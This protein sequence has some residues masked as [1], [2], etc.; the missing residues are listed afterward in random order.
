M[1]FVT[2]ISILSQ[3]TSTLL[4]SDIGSGPITGFPRSATSPVGFAFDDW[5]INNMSTLLLQTRNYWTSPPASFPS[6]AEWS[7]K[8]SA[9]EDYIKDTGPSLRAFLPF[10]S[11]DARLSTQAYEGIADVFD[12]S[13]VCA[14]PEI[15]LQNEER[16]NMSFGTLKHRNLSGQLG[17]RLR[18]LENRTSHFS[19]STFDLS[20]GS[21]LFIQLD[22]LAGGIVSDLDPTNN[23][24]VFNFHNE[25]FGGWSATRSRTASGH[26]HNSW[27]TE[28]GRRFLICSV[29]IVFTGRVIRSRF[30]T[31]IRRR[32]YSRRPWNTP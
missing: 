20:L 12:T 9:E 14:R 3:F 5:V 11:S 10:Q 18:L 21:F 13:V 25:T 22:V 15:T 6:F 2:L 1:L 32:L 23:A 28:L 17:D 30:G 31:N 27:N 16:D 19:F 7:E 4:L 29:S 26:G 24:T 8:P